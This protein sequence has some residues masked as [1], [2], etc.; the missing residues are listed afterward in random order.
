[1]F[2]VGLLPLW[3]TAVRNTI[4]KLLGW[5]S[6]PFAS[7]LA[8]SSCLD[9]TSEQT[10]G[11]TGLMPCIEKIER[12]IA[13]LRQ[14][15]A[16]LTHE[17]QGDS[18]YIVINTKSNR[19]LLRQGGRVLREAPCSTGSGRSLSYRWRNWKF[20]TPLGRFEVEKKV[21]GPTWVRP[22]WA[23]VEEGEPVP[24]F[25]EAFERFEPGVLGEFAL[26]F[27][28]GYMIHGTLYENR[29]GQPITHGCVRLRRQDLEYLF[30]HTS[31]GTP[32]YIL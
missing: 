11:T 22:A 16:E 28:E 7:L 5:A 26:H 21:E 6:V 20:H 12:D 4:L 13:A 8:S 19:I 1:M 27:A 2:C 17:I 23:F 9:A 24:V 31:V 10:L 3:G 15:N 29:I 30:S 25:A 14:R 18:C 32:I